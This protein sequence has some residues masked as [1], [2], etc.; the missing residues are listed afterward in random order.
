M[1]RYWE[2][3]HGR[4]YCYA[5]DALFECP[6]EGLWYE[7][8]DPETGEKTL[9]KRQPAERLGI[10]FSRAATPEQDNAAA[11]LGMDPVKLGA[12]IAQAHS[13]RGRERLRV[14]GRLTDRCGCCGARMER[15]GFRVW[16][17]EPVPEEELSSGQRTSAAISSRIFGGSGTQLRVIR[18]RWLD[19]KKEAR[20]WAYEEYRLAQATIAEMT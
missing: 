18:E 9:T 1:Y 17:D 3:G 14:D 4:R 10:T 19:T 5:K 7:L 6:H 8:T 13:R 12:M 20:A 16:I 2:D 11:V 15:K